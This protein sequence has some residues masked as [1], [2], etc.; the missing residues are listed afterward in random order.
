[1]SKYLLDSL[2]RREAAGMAFVLFGLLL[3]LAL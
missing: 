1:M 2:A 3:V